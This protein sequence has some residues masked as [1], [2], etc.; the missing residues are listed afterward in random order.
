[1]SLPEDVHALKSITH[2]DASSNSLQSLPA[3]LPHAHTLSSLS[4]ANNNLTNVDPFLGLMHLR[5]LV[6]DGNPLK[7]IRR[8]IIEGG[9]DRILSFLRD[10]IPHGALPP[11]PP[12]SVRVRG[13]SAPQHDSPPKGKISVSGDRVC[14][15]HEGGGSAI[16]I[17]E[18]DSFPRA[19]SLRAQKDLPSWQIEQLSTQE[20]HSVRGDPFR[21]QDV[22]SA[23]DQNLDGNRYHS[24]VHSHGTW[25]SVGSTELNHGS[26]GQCGCSGK[27]SELQQAV[28]VCERE[29]ERLQSVLD[30]GGLSQAVTFATKK[31]LAMERA[32]RGR[33]L[34]EIQQLG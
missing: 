3:S 4:L 15:P 18:R 11:P 5:A 9:T 32:N 33:H 16:A 22:S 13:D 6:L 1:M 30:G 21:D 23:Q 29:M 7:L 14:F 28:C 19:C 27:L 34:R 31:K 25:S 20:T 24:G 10:R 12:P 17:S 8:N 2:L 26:T